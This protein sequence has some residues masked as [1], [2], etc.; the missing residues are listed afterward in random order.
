MNRLPDW[1]ARLAAEMTIIR[2][3][4]FAW[5]EHDCL[6]GLIGSAVTAM[7]GEDPVAPWRG[8]YTTQA[9]A[10]RVLRRDGF[11]DLA[12]LAATLLP[13]LDHPS[14]A[15]VG[16]VM[17]IPSGDAFGHGL[18]LVDGERVFV[19]GEAMGLMTVDRASATRAWRVG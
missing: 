15:R 16:D 9:G 12:D 11:S 3:T 14:E 18:G 5:G 10:L 2:A 1:R 13:P 4:P 6:V 8:R 7:T 17:A 19:L